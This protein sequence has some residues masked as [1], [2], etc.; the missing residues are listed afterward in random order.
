MLIF[1]AVAAGAL[2]LS[3]TVVSAEAVDGSGRTADVCRDGKEG[4]ICEAAAMPIES[5]SGAS[6]DSDATVSSEPPQG[7]VHDIEE[8]DENEN[9]NEDAGPFL[10]HD[11]H[12]DCATW[13]R[14]VDEETGLDG[15]HHDRP[16]ML[17]ECA[18]SCRIVGVSV[19]TLTDEQIV[20]DAIKGYAYVIEGEHDSDDWD[21]CEDD[22]EECADWAEEAECMGNPSYLLEHCEKSCRVC[23]EPGVN[24]IQFGVEQRVDFYDADDIRI[25]T[26]EV[27]KNTLAY[28]VD[29]VMVDDKFLVARRDCFNHDPKCSYW[30]AQGECDGGDEEWMA[31]HC[32]PACQS[33]LSVEYW[34]RCGVDRDNPLHK[35]IIEKGD[36]N[37][38]FERIMEKEE[39]AR[40]NPVTLSRPYH[41]GEKDSEAA[42]E[43]RDGVEYILGPWIVLLDEFL[44][45]E[46]SE[47]LVKLGH[48]MKFEIS[49]EVSDT[50]KN[51]DGS[52][53]DDV[54][55][56]GRTS[57]NSWCSDECFDDPIA[58]RIRERIVD[59][60]GVPSDYSEHFQLLKYE[61]DEYYEEHHDYITSQQN[62][63]G[64][65][66]IITVFMYLNDVEEGGET[67]FPP[68]SN[69]TVSPKR[70]S[71]LI[72]PSVLDEDPEEIDERTFHT[73]LPVKKGIKYGANAWLHLRNYSAASDIDCD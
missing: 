43:P 40:Y 19:G 10:G 27:I 34:H 64:G 72:W 60:T 58:T 24:S 16:F 23:F 50:E 8:D 26:I 35:D 48:E 37:A 36:M 70:G 68:L 21:V 4:E 31:T 46:E 69:L 59:L 18:E 44:S 61:V 73:A 49:T 56:E 12:E 47:R 66:R 39:Y 54:P 15:C 22:D 20:E 67:A 1:A 38:M 11:L 33:C 32:S 42:E 3:T 52:Y 62:L 51:E 45:E 14:D 55:T 6:E 30:A 65:P 41:P 53:K 5:D 71:A 57:T 2:V 63:I 29:E 9:E 25:Q 28:M 17:S 7:R 13:A